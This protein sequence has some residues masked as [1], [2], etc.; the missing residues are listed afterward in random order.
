MAGAEVDEAEG[1]APAAAAAGPEEP[2]DA[3]SAQ[4]LAVPSS[5]AVAKTWQPPAEGDQSAD[6]ALRSCAST[7]SRGLPV[8]GSQTVAEPQ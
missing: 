7:S 5:D 3:L 8:A 4:T 2:R 6:Q 1:G